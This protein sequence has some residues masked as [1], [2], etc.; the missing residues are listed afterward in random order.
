VGNARPV[1]VITDSATD[2]PFS[3]RKQYGIEVV[4]LSLTFGDES[5]RD[6]MDL[7]SSDL[8]RE[9][10][11]RDLIPKTSQPPSSLFAAAF[12]AA[13]D[14]GMDVVCVDVSAEVSGTFNSAR[15]AA[16]AVD[17]ERIRVVDSRG[18]TMQAG[19]VPVAAARAARDGG[20]LE[21]VTHAA[22]DAI[23]H[24]QLLAVLKT[25]DNLYKGG[26]IGRARHMVGSA[27]G[28][29][30]ILG[31]VDGV[32]TPVERARTWKRAVDRAMSLVDHHGTPSDIAVLHVD[33]EADASSIADE[34]K[35]RFPNANIVVDW[36]GSV[37]LAYAG[38][39]AIGIATLAGPASTI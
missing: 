22:Q 35:N 14:R 15:I 11:K 2:V 4:P 23:T 25:R 28:I 30:P 32:V 7:T 33:N 1:A 21:T 29:K 26:R 12:R 31:L 38:P 39:G 24:T 20:D 9:I 19:W 17:P 37:I 27:L 6:G 5:F 8:L 18:A 3:L 36:A 10:R 34:L 16:E 13:L